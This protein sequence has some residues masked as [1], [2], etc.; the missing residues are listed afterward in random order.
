MSLGS[1]CASVFS[2]ARLLVGICCAVAAS[3]SLAG[4]AGAATVTGKAP[5]GYQVVML[6]PNGKA[7]KATGGRSFSLRGTLNKASLHLVKADGSYAGPVLLAGKGS[8]VY[9]TIS[10]LSNLKLGT[11]SLKRGYAVAKAPKGRYQR[12][13][14]YSVSA[15]S[16]KPIGAGRSGLVKVGNGVAPLAGING[17]G[18]D[19]DR[20]GI[21]GAFDIDDN[22]NL[23]IDNVDRTTRAG[24]A[25]IAQAAQVMSPGP[26]PGPGQQSAGFR[27]FSNFKIGGDQT[28]NVNAGISASALDTL[29]DELLPPTITLA[30]QVVG[31]STGNLDC[32]GNVYCLEHVVGGQTYP[33]VNFQP[34]AITTPGILPLATGPTN[35]AQISP[36]AISS[37]IGSGDAFLQVVGSA[38]Y[39]GTLN[40]VFNT[41]PAL[42]SFQV[43]GEAPVTVSYDSSGRTAQPGMSPQNRIEVPASESTVRLT[44]WRPQRRAVAG[45]AS[46][47]GWVDIGGL[48]YR[49]DAP[50][51]PAGTSRSSCNGAY[52]AVSA[53]PAGIAQ[54]SAGP[55]GVQDAA[56][57]AA[58][59]AGQTL[60]M[61]IDLA[62]CFDWPSVAT[63]GP[64]SEFKIDLQA[65]SVYGD[66]SA[67]MVYFKKTPA[68]P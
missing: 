40:F 15:R 29:V 3:A 17:Q 26:G 60:T 2:S 65:Q 18:H 45:E 59:A 63:S 21:P 24:R 4:A 58:S 46:T 22:G 5:K 37:Q 53:S 8:K 11:L 55:D 9:A 56:A 12:A 39:A 33:K 51:P 30:T 34:V 68:L 36:G 66:N 14:A 6:L 27:L 25:F 61:T 54:P 49:A 7:V 44:F 57:D 20:D 41:V 62:T 10:G 35:D 1:P 43:A 67:R 28:P 64:A 31:G 13:A 23:V 52:S 19:A 50:N 16:G 38:S 48:L 32:L 42:V 47:D